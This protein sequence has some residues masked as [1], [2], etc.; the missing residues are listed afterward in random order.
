MIYILYSFIA[1]LF[2]FFLTTLGALTVFSVKSNNNK[3]IALMLGFGG[4]VMVAASIFSLLNPAIEYSILLNYKPWIICMVGFIVGVVLILILDYFLSK[5]EE[6]SKSNKLM[7]LAVIIHNIPEGLAIG[8]AFGSLLKEISTSTLI[9]A[10]MLAVGIG[11]QN[12]PEGA[13]I[14]IPLSVT[15]T[16]KFKSFL[17]GAFSGVVE[18]IAAVIGAIL[19]SF[20]E[21]SLPFV[22][23]IAAAIMIFVVIDEIIFL[24]HTYHKRLTSIGFIFG[25]IIMMVLDLALS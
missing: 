7:V 5:K 13:A 6:S 17:I 3:L 11:L 25:F 18:P 4:G 12:F 14:S 22:L 23:V 24:S 8:V 21:L 2:T 20:I 1:G 15:G 9:G 16:K 10:I 19:V